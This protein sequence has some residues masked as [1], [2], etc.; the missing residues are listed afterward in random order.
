VADETGHRDA[1]RQSCDFEIAVFA[2]RQH[3]VVSLAQLLQAGLTRDA[4]RSRVRAGRLYRVHRGVYAVGHR[5]LTALGCAWA[6][7]LA[8]DGWLSHRWAAA[9]WHMTTWPAG[10]VHITTTAQRRSTDALRVHHSRTLSLDDLTHDPEH[11]LPVTTPMRTLRDLATTETPH[12]FER[13]CHRADHLR[14]I[15]ANQAGDS[16]R[17]KDALQALARTGPQITRND[18]EELLLEIV[19]AAGLP[20][21]L[22]NHVVLGEEVDFFWPE[23]RLIVETDGAATHLTRAAFENDRRRDAMLTRA[24]YRVIRFTWRQLNEEPELVAAILAGL[25][26]A[27]AAGAAR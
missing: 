2:E 26:G 1:L 8:T 6:A 25:L 23:A 13:L 5:R 17:L 10:A 7:V 14:L 24:G 19:A 21:P 4:I 27:T 3:G 9:V 22:V 16:R 15:G 11:G 18:F 20:Q 12:R